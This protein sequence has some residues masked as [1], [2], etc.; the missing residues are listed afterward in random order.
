MSTHGDAREERPKGGDVEGQKH[1]P[2]V[3]KGDGAAVERHV[4]YGVV[5]RVRQREARER[6]VLD[7]RRREATCTPGVSRG[8]R[9]G[10]TA[11]VYSTTSVGLLA[12][13]TVRSGPQCACAC[14][15]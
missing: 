13:S 7:L 9:Y 12:G 6:R 2:A 15:R 5:R 8:V 11:P 1:L 10:G 3:A 14:V 4:R